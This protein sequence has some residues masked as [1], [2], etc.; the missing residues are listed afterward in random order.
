MK[1]KIFL[2][3]DT[4]CHNLQLLNRYIIGKTKKGVYGLEKILQLGKE[5]NVPVNVFLDF[6]ECH[7]YGDDYLL[8]IINLINKYNQ[9]IYLHV[10]PDYIADPV[11]KHLWEYSKEEQKNILRQSINDYFR[12]CGRQDVL[13]FRAGAWGVNPDTYDVLAELADEFHI[14]D[15][16]DLS[17][18]YYSRWR[19]HL[20]YEEYGAAN[21]S[22]KYKNVTVFPNTTYIGFDYFGKKYAFEFAVPYKSLSESKAILRKNKLSNITYTMHSW[23]FIKRWFFLSNTIA[24]DELQ[25]KIFKKCVAFA[26]NNGYEFCDMHEYRLVEESDQ[27]INLCD[28]LK[29]KLQCLW[30]NYLRFADNG[31]SYIKYAPLYFLPYILLIF[32]ILF[33][34]L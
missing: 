10:H 26:Q 6:P 20:S 29:G 30:F 31:R 18:E 24:G 27:C 25:I 4:E 13:Y 16:V 19:C 2:T 11:R 3:V 1:K 12:F 8:S 33:I 22:K 32:I 34:V 9:K 23:D 21:A 15:I 17:Y 28:D 14:H 5:L 7:A